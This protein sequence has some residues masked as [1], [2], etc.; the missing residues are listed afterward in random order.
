PHVPRLPLIRGESPPH[1]VRCPHDRQPKGQCRVG[2]RPPCGA[3]SPYG[4]S[5]GSAAPPSTGSPDPAPPTSTG[6]N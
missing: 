4:D 3:R 1:A 6:S 2:A 5:T